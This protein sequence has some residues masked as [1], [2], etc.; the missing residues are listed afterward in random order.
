[1]H[2]HP[3]IQIPNTFPDNTSVCRYWKILI[4]PPNTDTGTFYA[5][6][7]DIDTDAQYPKS[8]TDILVLAVFYIISI[9]CFKQCYVHPFKNTYVSNIFSRKYLFFLP[10]S[11]YSVTH[12][13][14][15][16]VK[17]KNNTY[18]GKICFII[19]RTLFS[20]FVKK[21]MALFK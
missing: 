16:E 20:E 8:I 11:R 5:D 12:R 9:L 13:R 19:F 2:L 14:K 18:L 17:R 10:S 3:Q 15:W 1:M 6:S 21:N 4:Y 7:T